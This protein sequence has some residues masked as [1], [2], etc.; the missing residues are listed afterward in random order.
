MTKW[1]RHCD[2][3]STSPLAF[4]VGTEAVTTTSAGASLLISTDTVLSAVGT[5][6]ASPPFPFAPVLHWW[7]IKMPLAPLTPGLAEIRRRNRMHYPMA[8][9]RPRLTSSAEPA[10]AT[11]R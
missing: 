1:R 11:A 9:P 10:P 2:G 5:H 7:F 6:P 8:R 4:G 3:D